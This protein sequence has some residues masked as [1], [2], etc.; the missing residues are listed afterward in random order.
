MSSKELSEEVKTLLNNSRVRGVVSISPEM[1]SNI[2][3]EDLNNYIKN[4]I[5]KSLSEELLKNFSGYITEEYLKNS[6]QRKIDLI[7]FPT[8]S[9]KKIVQEMI[10]NGFEF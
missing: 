3:E 5:M 7:V 6:K 10:K 1:E 2:N 8:E 9:F 4:D